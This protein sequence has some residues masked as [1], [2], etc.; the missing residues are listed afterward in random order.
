MPG[1][2]TIL[3]VDDEPRVTRSLKRA[4]R[5]S[6]WRILEASSAVEALEILDVEEVDVLVSDE[7]M[8]GMPGSRL[9][10]EAAARRPDTVR[11]MLTGHASLDAAVRAINEGQVFRFYLKPVD[12]GQLELGIRQGLRFRELLRASRRLLA[13]ERAAASPLRSPSR[14][15]VRRDE[16]G[17]IV[18]DH[19]EVDVE[20]LID[21]LERWFGGR[22][23]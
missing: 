20:A 4:L 2:T 7:R 9:L 19:E 15:S 21:E 3:L 17:A 16:S 5:R 6:G 8:P 22:S 13:R 23:S 18:L 14:E 12:E 10:A 1:P 11:I